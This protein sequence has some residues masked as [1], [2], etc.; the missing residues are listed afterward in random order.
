MKFLNEKA[1]KSE[2]L[3]LGYLWLERPSSGKHRSAIVPTKSISIKKFIAPLKS[4]KPLMAT[5]STSA[6]RREALPM[7]RKCR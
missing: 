6:I 7:A 4:A 1:I 2:A 5:M 3:V